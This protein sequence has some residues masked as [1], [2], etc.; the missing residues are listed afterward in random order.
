MA[1]FALE[2]MGRRPPKPRILI[3]G[4]GMGFTLRATLDVFPDAESVCVAELLPAVVAYN[5]GPLGELAG[6]PLDDPQVEIFEG[7]VRD[8]MSL[9]RWDLILLDV[10]NGPDPLTMK[11]NR[12]LYSLRGVRRAA[13][14]LAKGGLLV[15]WS[16]APSSPFETRLRTAGLEVI[17]RAVRARWPARK[18]PTHTL[19]LARNET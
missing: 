5:R 1:S 6:R 13:N 18:G 11:S 8:A 17:T 12:S 9:G 7:D 16:A 19:F 14:S 10:D 4:L 2:A 15:V 3:G